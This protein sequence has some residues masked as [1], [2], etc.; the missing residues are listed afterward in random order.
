MRAARSVVA[1]LLLAGCAVHPVPTTVAVA[2][3]PNPEEALRESMRHVASEMA[4]IDGVSRASTQAAAPVVPDELQRV[5]SF[6]WNGSLD[7]GV[8]K[9]A[10]SV[11]YTFFTTA[12]PNTRPLTVAIKISSV[13]AYQVLQM[14]GAEAGGRATVQVDPLHHQVEVIHHV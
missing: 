5:V 2:G 1:A 4:E 3:M 9:L 6:E 10:Q 12:P 7:E 8:A 11:G 14:L 13:S